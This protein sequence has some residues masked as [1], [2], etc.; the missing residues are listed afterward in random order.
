VKELLAGVRRRLRLAWAVATAELLG[1]VVAA[2]ALVLVLVGRARPWTWPEPGALAVGAVSAAGLLVTT[3]LL[4]VPETVAARAADRGLATGDAFFTA[5]ELDARSNDGPFAERVRARARDLAAGHRPADA[6]PVRPSGGRWLVVAVLATAAVALAL[7]SNAQDGVRRRRDAER[8][9]LAGEAAK[10]REA[11]ADVRGTAQPPAAQELVARQLEELARQLLQA[12][13]V[14]A[15]GQA[16][17]AAARDLSSRLTSGLLAEK[18]AVRGLDRSLAAAPLPGSAQGDAAAQ[19]KAEA[20]AVAGLSA[21]A[22]AAL[23]DRLAALAA[24]QTAGDPQGSAALAAAAAALRAGD[25]AGA[26]SA[27]AAAAAAQTAAASDVGDQEAALAGLAAVAAAQDGLAAGGSA[28]GQGSNGQGSQGSQG[29]QGQGQGSNGQGSNGQGQGQGQGS[30]QQ[31]QGAGSPSGQVGGT[32]AQQGSGTGGAGTPNGTGHNPSVGLQTATVFEPP[33]AGSDGQQLNAAGPQG[34]GPSQAAG[35]AD[36]PTQ[37]N[38]AQV[39]LA[40]VLPRY[41]AEATRALNQLNIPPSQRALV[42]SYFSSLADG[43]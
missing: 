7:T 32:N 6:V 22:R 37:R 1:P 38:S 27:L 10:L 16:L 4:R 39:P 34:Q 31:G 21:E 23:A 24:T 17:D 25:T 2:V 42:Q 12:P 29:S 13:D 43:Q 11:A 41:A 20:A 19:L 40:D 8:R 36:G 30:G 33:P 26:A 18:A 35:K 14:A 5:L 9:V 3:V 15:G 28:Q